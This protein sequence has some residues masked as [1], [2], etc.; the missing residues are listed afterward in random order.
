MQIKKFIKEQ[1]LNKVNNELMELESSAKSAYDLN[2]ATDLKSEG[3]YDTRA[4]EAGYLAGALKKRVDE[5]KLE[6]QLYEEI[7]VKEFLKTEQV[8]I[9]AIIELEYLKKSQKYYLSSTGG[10]H[11]IDT[12]LGSILVISVF[13]PIGCEVLGLKIGE[14]FEVETPKITREYKVVNLF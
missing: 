13:S 9:G 14:S 10:G 3:K 2:T 8:A 1:L 11:F 6:L 12:D 7:E 4:V 5:L